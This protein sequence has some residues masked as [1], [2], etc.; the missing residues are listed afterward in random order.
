[1]MP[2]LR[3][4]GAAAML[5]LTATWPTSLAWASGDERDPYNNDAQP[6]TI[7]LHVPPVAPGT[8]TSVTVQVIGATKH[9]PPHVRMATNASPSA[10]TVVA[11]RSGNESVAEVTVDV[12]RPFA[13]NL[14]P[15]TRTPGCGPH[16]APNTPGC[17]STADAAAPPVGPEQ[18]D[19]AVQAPRAALV[20]AGGPATSVLYAVQPGDTLERIARRFYGEP[21][22]VARI[23]AANAERAMP[24]GHVLRDPR[25]IRAGWVLALPAPARAVE[26]RHGTRWYTVQPG[27]SLAS[28]A[29]E[30]LGDERQWPAVYALN[31]DTLA[32]PGL[33]QPGTRLRLPTA[34]SAVAGGPRPTATSDIDSSELAEDAPVSPP[35]AAAPAT[36]AL[37]ASAGDQRDGLVVAST[38]ATRLPQVPTS[39]PASDR[40][41][42]SS[43]T[44]IPAAAAAITTPWV[45]PVDGQQAVR[46]AQGQ[47]LILPSDAQ[48]VVSPVDAQPSA[49]GGHERVSPAAEQVS[50]SR[51]D[52]QQ[53]LSPADEQASVRPPDGKASVRPADRQLS[54]RS[55]EGQPLASPAFGRSPAQ[56]CPQSGLAL[57]RS[58]LPIAPLAAAGAAVAVL[59]GLFRWAA[60]NRRPR[61]SD[62]VRDA[63]P[64]RPVAQP[65]ARMATREQQREQVLDAVVEG[66]LTQAAA[67]AVL[68]LSVRQL[69]RLLAAYRS[70]GAA[71]LVHAN[72]GRAP[73]QAISPSIKAQV[74]ALA[75]ERYVG[76]SQQQ[77][78]DRLAHEHGIV[79][80]RTTVR[81]ILLEAADGGQAAAAAPMAGDKHANR[82]ADRPALARMPG[83]HSCLGQG[84]VPGCRCLQ[85]ATG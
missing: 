46:P 19:E 6:V 56:P 43:A 40:L 77:L 63:Q 69:R 58:V 41:E 13:W 74:V 14:V 34:G 80:H 3:A 15:P 18:S 5:L 24:D 51:A 60:S 64:A 29:A 82:A 44:P 55:V 78:T 23:L 47:P 75:R 76:L 9:G 71:G 83:R 8:T 10:P 25:L 61:P 2:L 11:A 65:P 50:A 32:Q 59:V 33:I 20:N 36:A 42:S 16:P 35:S 57:A 12:E 37:G 73:W 4:C 1:M 49:A 72:R 66:K 39:A 67:A 79:L 22:A 52:G 85:P 30:L 84:R 17:S 31:R 26:D 70:Q 68:D 45:S 62:G 7:D 48:P 54:V 53:W 38:A 27:D 28:I 21:A 81:R